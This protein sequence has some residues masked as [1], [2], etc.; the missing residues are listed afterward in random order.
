M[1]INKAD[2]IEYTAPTANDLTYNG[3][4]QALITKG[5]AT[6][7]SMMYAIGTA[8]QVTGGW[9]ADAP[10]GAD[11]GSY[12]VWYKVV[13]DR[14]HNDKTFDSPVT[15]TVAPNKYTVKFVNEGGAVLQSS[16]VTYGETPAYTGETPTKAATDQYSYTFKGW[17]P[18]IETVTGDVTYTATYTETVNK[19]T[20]TFYDE[21]GTTVLESKE[22]EYGRT[23]VYNNGQNPTKTA[24]AE[25]TYV[26]AGW[27]P[28]VAAVTGT[29]SYIATFTDATNSYTVTW[30]DE[31]GTTVLETTSWPYG[32]TPNFTGSTPSKTAD[33]QYTYTF[34]RWIPVSGVDTDGKITG[35]AGFKAVYSAT[36]NTYTVTWKNDDT[37]LETDMNVPYGAT[38]SYDGDTPTKAATAQYTYIFKGWD[39]EIG[40]VTGNITYTAQFDS[41][42]NQYTVTYDVANGN[43]PTSVEVNYGDRVAAPADPAKEG[44]IFAG[45]Y[46]DAEGGEQFDFNEAITENITLYAHWSSE[47]VYDITGRVEQ[48]QQSGNPTPAEGV[49]VTLRQ[50]NRVL[51]TKTTDADGLYD[52][53]APAGS[54]NIVAEK[55][56][57]TMTQL[58]NVTDHNE[59]VGEIILPYQNVSSE[60][61]I[62]VGTPDI[63]VGGL[64]EE[65]V[66]SNPNATSNET[67]IT[68]SMTVE[69]KEDVTSSEAPEYAELKAEQE[70]IKTKAGGQKENLTFLKID[71]TKVITGDGAGSEPVTTTTNLLKIIIPFETSGRQAFKVYRYHGS[72]V[73]VLTTTTNADGEYIEISTGSIIIH[74]KKFST[75]A[76]GYTVPASSG[77][78][79]PTYAITVEKSENGEVKVNRSYASS[80]ATVTITV[81]S[82]DGYV[83]KELSV[84]DSQGNEI[85]VTNKGDGTYTFKMPHRK[86]T[87]TASFATDGSFSVCPK[88]NTCPI[89]PYT[90]AETT[91]WYH[92]GVHY[93]IENGLMAGYGDGIFKP[94]AD[95]TRAMITVML[96]RLNGSPVVNYLMDFEDVEDGKWYTEAIRWAKSERI[97]E[98]YGNGFF[99]TNDAITREQMVTILWRYAQYKGID[100]SV[101]EDTNIL[102]Y[103]DAFDVSEYA[104]PAMQWACGS[105]MVQGMNDPNGEGMILAPESKGTR[106]QIA[107]MMM[108]F[109]EEILK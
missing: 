21:D 101:G 14:N 89:W 94:N 68:L 11:I 20:V 57:K 58:V 30:Y 75:Y 80:G 27:S 10:T 55:D 37:V 74:A 5:S 43:A 44:Y 59:Q 106:A 102:S 28:A 34:E 47:P 53:H 65:V 16:E 91:A 35:T 67:H 60:L 61:T 1:T 86:V 70:E 6:G 38:P 84:T 41:T 51:F 29:A 32:S 19:Y 76:I 40:V 36:V 85:E 105:G 18:E 23:P 50:G 79:T 108:R 31:D 25:K 107:T 81:T 39:K 83:L 9:S 90:D 46:T 63:V 26:F 15:V 33:T 88:D 56:G 92:D 24:T 62:P 8:G 96:W 95:T 49:T 104:I 17:T 54:Y 22:W 13:G 72:D 97:A 82:E 71:L 78:Y 66:E 98:G 45:W 100:V 12:Y 3:S 52:F 64:D 99:G 7:G 109:C 87:V 93:C 73:D 4:A 69:Q 42:I 48:A 103:N 77:G 2:I